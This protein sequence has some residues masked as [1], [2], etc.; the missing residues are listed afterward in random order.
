MRQSYNGAMECILVDD[1]G[2][3][4]S[5]EIAEQLIKAYNGPIDFKVVHH[6]HNQGLSAARNTGMDASCGE[7]VYFLDSDDWISDDCILKH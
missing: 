4:N 5:M 1:C 3:D 7:Y 2:T 6:E